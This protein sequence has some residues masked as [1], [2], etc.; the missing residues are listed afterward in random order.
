MKFRFLA[1]FPAAL[2]LGGCWDSAFF[3]PPP[4]GSSDTALPAARESELTLSAS[5][6][7]QEI[8]KL[9]N[10]LIP[11]SF[12]IRGHNPI[13]CIEWPTGISVS[14]PR[15]DTERKCAHANWNATI[16]KKEGV[17]VGKSGAAISIGQAIRIGGQAG[18][19]G[20]LASLLSLSGKRFDVDVTPRAEL[21]VGINTDW[22]PIVDVNPIGR[23]VKSANVEIVGESCTGVK[24]PPLVDV[25]LCAG[26]TN[27]DLGDV[28]QSELDQ[29]KGDITAA[30]RNSISCSD[31][32]KPIEAQ[33][34]DRAIKVQSV[35]G[36][37]LFLNLQPTS[38]AFS[39][40]V[41]DEDRLR[42]AARVKVIA[43]LS[44]VSIPETV[45]PLP[46]LQAIPAGDGGFNIEV[47]ALAPYSLIQAALMGELKE[48][49][50]EN[51]VPGGR[52][53]VKILDIDVYP[54]G[55]SLAIGIK[56]DAKL[57]NRWLNTSGWLYLSA[58]PIILPGGHKIALQNIKY[59]TVID[60]SIWK[61]VQAVIGDK[62]LEILQ[63]KS[64]IDLSSQLDDRSKAV[65]DAIKAASAPGLRLKPGMVT[66]GIRA[67]HIGSSE[68]V[69]DAMLSMPLEV[70]VD[71]HIVK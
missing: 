17:S 10:T 69:T 51:E 45:K 52:A 25:R 11:A 30:A 35:G 46:P 56:I 33:W 12:S 16:A 23:W 58:T 57:P 60:N 5:M 67:V 68:L 43:S 32:K 41:A 34:R 26:P 42:V 24:I 61:L 7:Y 40:F 39:G 44:P 55:K 54:S 31:V 4:R 64:L 29:K 63:E 47:R 18:V 37:E 66:I 14:P 50:L 13:A 71:A 53:S 27:V 22:C 49:I 36:Q 62:I 21:K 59:A 20:D 6:Q 65:S 8:E 19:G 48:K 2:G 38:A 9:A 1:V 3:E 70:E 28:V 15:I